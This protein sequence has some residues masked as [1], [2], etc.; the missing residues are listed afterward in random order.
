MQPFDYPLLLTPRFDAKIWGGRKLESVLGKSLP[1]DSPYGE[2]LESDDGSKILNGPLAGATIGDL[3]RQDADALLGPRGALANSGQVGF[4][5]LAKFIDAADVLSVQVHPDDDEARPLGKRGKTEAWHIIA[6][7][8]DSTLITGIKPEVSIGQIAQAIAEVRLGE[9]VIE[10]PVEAGDTLLVPAGTTHAIGAGIL[11]Y[12]IQQASDV[13]FRMYDWGRLDD[14]GHPREL[15][16]EKSLA[17]VKPDLQARRIHPLRLSQG[18][19]MLAACR[20][21]ALERWDLSGKLQEIPFDGGSFRLASSISGTATLTAGG[22]TIELP[23][24]QTALIPANVRELAI[25]GEGCLL[26]SYVP[27]LQQDVIEPLR[28]ASYSDDEI[29]GLAG[30]LDHL[31]PA[32]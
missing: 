24:G 30:M 32:D 8:P 6:A 1:D 4:P 3:I 15:H 11:L 5:L 18:R 25:S 28:H 10:Q 7:E 16:V 2:S 14:N 22:Q 9:Y 21:F 27:D 13:T 31:Q 19:Q 26:V 12:E 23:A 29:A 20:Y 17:V